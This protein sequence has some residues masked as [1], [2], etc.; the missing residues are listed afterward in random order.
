MLKHVKMTSLADKLYGTPKEEKKVKKEAKK[1]GLLGRKK[2][3]KS[4]K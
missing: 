3:Y 1:E 2:D 4:K